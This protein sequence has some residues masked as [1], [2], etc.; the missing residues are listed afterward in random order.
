MHGY[1][2]VRFWAAIDPM[3]TPPMFQYFVGGI[4]GATRTLEQVFSPIW[5]SARRGAPVNAETSARTAMRT[6]SV[7][8]A[9]V[10][11]RDNENPLLEMR[12]GRP[13]NVPSASGRYLPVR[14][15]V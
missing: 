1:K 5:P 12:L 3:P 11:E 7:T 10:N 6:S 8:P 2:R 14:R 4:D 9:G 13:E 15:R